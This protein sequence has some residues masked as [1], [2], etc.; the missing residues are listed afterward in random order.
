MTLGHW[1]CLAP[2][3]FIV[4]GYIIEQRN[5]KRRHGSDF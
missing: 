1:L 4:V 5:F 2:V 3:A